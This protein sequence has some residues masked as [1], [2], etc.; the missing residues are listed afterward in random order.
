MFMLM[1]FILELYLLNVPKG[2]IYWGSF[3]VIYSYYMF[4]CCLMFL[5][6]QHEIG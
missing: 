2:H 4:S 1:I 5:K 6:N 3:I